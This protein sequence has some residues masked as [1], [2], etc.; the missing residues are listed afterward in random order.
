VACASEQCIHAYSQ[1]YTGVGA[2]SACG[3]VLWP[4]DHETPTGVHSLSAVSA[5]PWCALLT[6]SFPCLQAIVMSHIYVTGEFVK[7][8]LYVANPC[9]S[10]CAHFTTSPAAGSQNN[11]VGVSCVWSLLSSSRAGRVKHS[12]VC[13][14]CLFELAIRL[15][16]RSC[17]KQPSSQHQ[18]AACSQAAGVKAAAAQQQA[19]K[20]QWAAKQAAAEAHA[21]RSSRGRA[22]GLASC[23]VPQV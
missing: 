1:G 20:Q 4:P 11:Q 13:F 15:C 3:S 2:W 21:P 18:R 5:G 10:S 14:A 23:P 17:R 7:P 22:Q 8:W 12:E 19:L 9:F 16:C 6:S